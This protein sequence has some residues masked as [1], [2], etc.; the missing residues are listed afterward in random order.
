MSGLQKIY[1][2]AGLFLLCIYVIPASAGGPLIVTGYTSTQPGQPYRWVSNPIT[3]KTDLGSLGNQTNSQANALVTSAFQVWQSVP[4]TSLN[5]TM[6]G[7]LSSDVTGVLDFTIDPINGYPA[8]FMNFHNAMTNCNDPSQPMNAI[9]Y[10]LDGSIIK[11]AYGYD[12]NSVMGFSQIV[13]ADDTAGTITRGWAVLNGRFID[14]QPKTDNH[15]TVTLDEFKAVFVHEFGHLL[16]LDHSQINLNCLTDDTCSADD[17]A[18][19]PI[20]FPILL[21]QSTGSLSADDR[22][23]ISALYPAASLSTTMGRIQG[24]VFFSDGRT[25]AQGYN[26]IARQVGN[27]RRVAVST[28]S[29]YFYTPWPGS[30]PSPETGIPLAPENSLNVYNYGYYGSL[31]ANLIGYFD[32]Q[33]IPPGTYTL[34]VEAIN[35]VG[36][37][38]F[39]EASAVGPTGNLSDASFQYTMPGT[40]A[41]QYLHNPSSPADSCSAQST[42]TVGGGYITNTNT[43]II[44]LG[45]ETRY[46]QWE[47]GP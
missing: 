13:C 16:G 39:T 41:L 20:M 14:G 46:D 40:C 32:I 31:D 36:D 19:L 15:D 1:L 11:E 3:Y 25:P 9:V 12:N 42:L 10:D 21:Y 47:D 7:Q 35:G 5:I 29:G 33:G 30:P 23:A 43:D 26:V 22:A 18:G 45:T 28:V 2:L 38:P 6:T 4:T 8:V 24:H 17:A 44:I 34:E 37:Y 27:P